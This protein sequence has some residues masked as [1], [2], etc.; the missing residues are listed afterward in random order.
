[1]DEER[2]GDLVAR[3]SSVIQA[4]SQGAKKSA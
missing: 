3:A 2:M 4:L 1:V